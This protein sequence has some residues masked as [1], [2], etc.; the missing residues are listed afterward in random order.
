MIV[1]LLGPAPIISGAGLLLFGTE[2]CYQTPG[3]SVSS[4]SIITTF[5]SLSPAGD[6]GYCTIRNHG[7]APVSERARAAHDFHCV[8]DIPPGSGQFHLAPGFKVNGIPG[9]FGN[10]LRAVR[11]QQLAC[12]VMNFDF[13]HGAILLNSARP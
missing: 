3:K 12:V 11:F 10:S 1:L 5:S 9:G 8:F 13:S 4:R 7:L 2:K 6:L